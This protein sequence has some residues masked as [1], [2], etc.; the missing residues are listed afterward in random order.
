MKRDMK[1]LPPI[2]VKG[3]MSLPKLWSQR[4]PFLE[5]ICR[6]EKYYRLRKIYVFCSFCKEYVNAK[7]G[8]SA[9]DW[10]KDFLGKYKTSHSVCI[11]CAKEHYGIDLSVDTE[12]RGGAQ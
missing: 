4:E 2:P 5:E 7:T 6:S 12:V 10:V 3:R 11:P 8:F 9:P 1:S